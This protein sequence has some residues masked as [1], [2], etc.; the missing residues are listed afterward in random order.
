MKRM[1]LP[2]IAALV[3]LASASLPVKPEELK[4]IKARLGTE[5][6]ISQAAQD[7][8]EQWCQLMERFYE[9]DV[10]YDD[11]TEPEKKLFN[12]F[13]PDM[14]LW[15]TQPGGCSWYCGGWPEGVFASSFLAAQSGN[16]YVASN[17]HDFDMRTA[18]VEG[19]KGYGIGEYIEVY[20]SPFGPRITEIVVYNGYF[21]SIEAW[22][23]NSRVK[24]LKFY[25]GK[26]P[27]AILELEDCR[28]PQY[29]DIEPLQSVDKNLSLV[30]RFEILEAYKG[31]KWD[32]VA[33]S[34]I[35]FDGLDV[36]CFVKGT[37]IAMA[38]GTEKAI[39][40]V[41]PGD[42]V[43]SYNISEQKLEH[44]MV[45]EVASA[46]HDNLVQLDF[47][48]AIVTATDDH[49]FYIKDKGWCSVNPEKTRI[50]R[51]M[52]NATALAIGDAAYYL[53]AQGKVAIATLQQIAH[54]E[55]GAA[56]ATGTETF[57]VTKLEGQNGNFFANGLLVGI[58]E[59]SRIE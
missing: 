23:N 43:L 54:L 7:R 19:V 36:H 18:W 27:Y 21:K 38:N 8:Y 57:T 16:T 26:K 15:D 33:I 31:N 47:G 41:A 13:P 28:A 49:P 59:L 52:E 35:N 5:V 58:E 55:N 20:F 4:V 37:K 1:I 12:E 2:V 11:L 45:V 39:E 3:V 34:E 10:K 50:Y 51:N 53:D 29:F 46:T 32:D 6:D 42:M 25:V 40:F 24:R 30:L 56:A 17:A 44:S 48:C 14:G 9:E 22:E